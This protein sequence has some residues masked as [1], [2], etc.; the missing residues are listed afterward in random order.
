MV[1]VPGV[2]VL[3]GLLFALLKGCERRFLGLDTFWVRP[4]L[5]AKVEDG[6]TRSGSASR[7]V[8]CIEVMGRLVD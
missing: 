6:G 2:M 3:G 5:G 4:I 8:F 1:F 7:W